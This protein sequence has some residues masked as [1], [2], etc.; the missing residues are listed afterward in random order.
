MRLSRPVNST[1]DAIIAAFSSGLSI[2]V[3]AVIDMMSIIFQGPQTFKNKTLGLVGKW[4]G[5]Q[6]DDLTTPQG[7]VISPDSTSRQIHYDFGLTCEL[8][9]HIVSLVDTDAAVC[10]EYT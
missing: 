4:N 6:E 1:E 9:N 2:T 5:I 10:K 7:T 8:D 3:T